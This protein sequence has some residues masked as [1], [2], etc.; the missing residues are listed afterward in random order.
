MKYHIKSLA[1][2]LLCCACSNSFE[3]AS[4]SGEVSLAGDW[5]YEA[6]AESLADPEKIEAAKCEGGK[7]VLVCHVPPGNPAARH[8]ICIGMP[9]VEHH[10]KHH[11]G[12]GAQDYLGDCAQPVPTPN[13]EPTPTPAPDP[14]PTPAPTPAPDPM[15]TPAP[16]PAPNPEPTPAPTPVPDPDNNF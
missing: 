10:L 15:P 11:D 5:P 16:T 13:P 7:K 14:M 4:S 8:T 3:Q 1:I 12:E 9:A 6:L 2:A